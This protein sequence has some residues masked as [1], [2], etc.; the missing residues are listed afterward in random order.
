MNLAEFVDWLSTQS[1]WLRLAVACPCMMLAALG[2][3][4]VIVTTAGREDS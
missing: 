2:G 4:V 1:A 3:L